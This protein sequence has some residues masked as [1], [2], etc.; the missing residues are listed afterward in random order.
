M[1]NQVNGTPVYVTKLELDNTKMLGVVKSQDTTVKG[2]EWFG[3]SDG[4]FDRPQLH[5]L[6][7]FEEFNKAIKT[8]VH[9]YVTS[10]MCP[11]MYKD[12]EINIYV[13]KSWGVKIKENGAVN[14]HKHCNGHISLVYYLSTPPGSSALH[15]LSD[16]PLDQ[17]N[18][19]Q[20]AQQSIFPKLNVETNTLVIFPGMCG[21]AALNNSS[22]ENRWSMSYDLMVT[23]PEARQF[24]TLDPKFWKLLD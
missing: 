3:D 1:I 8:H 11:M 14:P 18:S 6:P 9:E 4:E 13:Q 12:A 22:K 17:Y 15:F 16:N 5:N 19:F 10:I 24:M 21:H 20:T 7:E 2:N 23:T